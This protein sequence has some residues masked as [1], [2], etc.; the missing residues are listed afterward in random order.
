MLVLENGGI[1]YEVHV[2]L[3]TYSKLKD[4]D[5]VKLPVFLYLN[6]TQNGTVYA[7]YGFAEEEEKNIFLKLTSVSGVGMNTALILLSSLQPMEVA[8]AILGEQVAVFQRVKGIGEKIAKRIILELKDKMA[9]EGLTA[10]GEIVFSENKSREEAISAL[11]ALGFNKINVQK[12]L[13]GLLKDQ[14]AAN[15]EQL[16]RGAL[17][18]LS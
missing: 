1:G 10:T 2:S 7:F 11:V 15:T 5:E 17:R 6:A 3:N 9:K 18:L 4:A 13:N 14:P 8:Q 16:V 12:A